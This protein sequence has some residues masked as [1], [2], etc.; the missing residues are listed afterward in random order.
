M[1]ISLQEVKEKESKDTH[2]FF[3]KSKIL[4]E[5]IYSLDKKWCVEF[6]ENHYFFFGIEIF[7]TKKEVVKRNCVKTSL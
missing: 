1:P 2:P 7:A 4:L 5:R 6:W 3:G